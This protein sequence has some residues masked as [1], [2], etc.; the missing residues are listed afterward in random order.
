MSYFAIADRLALTQCYERQRTG[1]CDHVAKRGKLKGK[2]PCD[3]TQEFIDACS[4]PTPKQK[5]E[6]LEHLRE[7]RCRNLGCNHKSCNDVDGLV[8]WLDYEL[9]V[10]A[11][12]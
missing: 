1:T 11:A 10:A 9:R 8:R 5:I 6:I 7:K 3:I 2:N 12:A 4:D